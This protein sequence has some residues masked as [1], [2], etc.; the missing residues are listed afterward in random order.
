M[1]SKWA[2][3]MTFGIVL[4]V[5]LTVGMGIVLFGFPNPGGTADPALYEWGSLSALL[6]A[7][8]MIWATFFMK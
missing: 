1:P 7:A 4:L 2:W 6:G 3:T 5:P 8:V